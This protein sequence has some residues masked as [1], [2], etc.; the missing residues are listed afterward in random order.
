MK[1]TIIVSVV[2]I[3]ACVGVYL[4]TKNSTNNNHSIN[5]QKGATTTIDVGTVSTSTE[6]IK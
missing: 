6:Q 1:K 3:L 4:L 5:T 2:V